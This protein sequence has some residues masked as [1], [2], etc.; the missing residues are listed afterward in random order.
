MTRRV[1]ALAI[2]LAALAACGTKQAERPP[3]PARMLAVL[4]LEDGPDVRKGATPQEDGGQIVTAQIY[5]VLAEQTAYRFAPDLTVAD[6]IATAEVRGAGSQLARAVALGK[7][8]G[9]DAV[10]IGSVTRFA[11]RVGT[12]FGA[13]QGASVAFRLGLVAVGSG[14]EIWNGAFD[15]TQE[16]LATNFFGFWMFWSAGPRW[17]TANELAGLGVE[18]LWPQLTSA[19][20]A[21]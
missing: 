8:V 10:I 20:T 15:E 14:E 19:I 4:P 12:A 13:S 5:R 21:E 9:A 2:A 11:P 7:A 1:A 17:L 3:L 18:R 6:T 16:A